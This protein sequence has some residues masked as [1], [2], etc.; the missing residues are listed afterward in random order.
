MVHEKS[1]GAAELSVRSCVW[2]PPGDG[3]GGVREICPTYQ[4]RVMEGGTIIL[5]A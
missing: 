2:G 5:I 1:L 3:I 4:S